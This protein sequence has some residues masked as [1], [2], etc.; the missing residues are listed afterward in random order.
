MKFAGEFLVNAPRETVFN[1]LRDARFF[2][3]CIDGVGELT[4]VDPTHYTAQFE[5][6]VAYMKFRFDV[7]VELVRENPPELLEGRIEGKPIGIVGRLV[8]TSSTR[9]TP[10][11]GG[12]K[13]EYEIEASLAGKLGSIGQPVLRSK[14]KD[15]ETI[16]T[17]RLRE[18]FRAA[19][20]AQ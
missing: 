7:A 4:E 1:A 3:S 18:A 12:T 20:A 14:A 17:K 8:A 13:V 6:R 16:F 10:A 2:A 15:M 9:L 5:T 19:E 11:D